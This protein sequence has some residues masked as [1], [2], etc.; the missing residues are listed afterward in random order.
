MEQ[1]NNIDKRLLWVA[2][3][4]PVEAYNAD[5]AGMEALVNNFPQSGLLRAL[6]A[7]NGRDHNIKRAAVYV[8]PIAL[9]KQVNHRDALAV[10]NPTQI[11]GN[12]ILSVLPDTRV[13][14]VAENQES[15]EIVNHFSERYNEPGIEEAGTLIDDIEEQSFAVNAEPT[16][17]DAQPNEEVAE[18][19]EPQQ[20]ET[21][22][23]VEPGYTLDKAEFFHQDIEDEVYDEIVSIED[24]KIEQ[25]YTA[26]PE[27]A[28]IPQDDIT[29]PV[30]QIPVN[31]HF[32]FDN[33]FAQKQTNTAIQVATVPRNLNTENKDVSRYN[34]DKMPYSFM[35]WLDKTRKEYAETYQPYTYN[36]PTAP[37]SAPAAKPQVDELQQQY[38]ENIFNLNAIEQ[39]EKNTPNKPVNFTDKKEDRIIKRFIQTEPQI[40]HPTGV[41]LDNENKAK[42]SSED[43]EEFVTETLAK[44]YTEQMLYPKAIAAYKKL[45]LKFPEKSLYFAS[46]IEQLEKKSN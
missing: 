8:D 16:E 17:I 19:I 41:I 31:D 36:G 37:P 38:V 33:S 2:L 18:V 45:M 23:A 5:A 3:A 14:T 10:V 13:E 24:I 6:L 35:W 32:V 12:D 4:N 46:Q 30:N 43:V 39:L 7:C 40:K 25:V 44:I 21:Y 28:Q 26:V 11:I 20:E 29:Q 15:E 1:L 22:H 27:A 34:D 42:K 9:Y